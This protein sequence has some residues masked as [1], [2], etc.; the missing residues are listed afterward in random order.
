MLRFTILALVFLSATLAG[1][2]WITAHSPGSPLGK[3]TPDAAVLIEVG[4]CADPGKAALAGTAEGLIDGRRKSIPLTFTRTSKPG[5]FAVKKQW[6]GTGPWVLAIT[7][8]YL[9]HP[10]SLVVEVGTKGD[11]RS[12]AVD[13][14]ELSARVEAALKAS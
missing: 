5:V 8:T 4:G 6:N 11:Y 9:G 1:G 13:P 10:S 2:F 12:K 7:G 3:Q 14:K